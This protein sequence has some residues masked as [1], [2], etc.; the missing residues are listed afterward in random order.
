MDHVTFVGGKPSVVITS[1][2]LTCMGWYL[3][4]NKSSSG[5]HN[6]ANSIRGSCNLLAIDM[7]CRNTTGYSLKSAY[8]KRK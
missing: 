3:R 1:T 2:Y 6:C 4:H 7:A 8:K 5:L